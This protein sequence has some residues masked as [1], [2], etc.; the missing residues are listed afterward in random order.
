MATACVLMWKPSASSAI[1]LYPQPAAISSTIMAPVIHITARV[2]RSPAALPWSNWCEWVQA[3]RLVVCMGCSFVRC[4]GHRVMS[5]NYRCAAG[6]ARRLR[7]AGGA[8]ADAPALLD[9][10]DVAPVALGRA[11]M[12]DA[13]RGLAGHAALLRGQ[14][15]QAQALGGFFIQLLGHRC[16]PAQAA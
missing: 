12:F 7:V 9:F 3:L 4:A 2:P 1:E 11:P 16:R 5:V 13:A 15:A 8:P 14:R 6:A 10:L